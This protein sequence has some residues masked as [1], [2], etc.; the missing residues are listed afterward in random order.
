MIART[1][2]A[3][4]VTEP[5][6]QLAYDLL[7]K[8]L[9]VIQQSSPKLYDEAQHHSFA[10]RAALNEQQLAND[11]RTKRLK[12]SADPIGDLKSEA[13]SAKTKAERDE[14]LLRAAEL[15][16]ERKKFQLCLDILDSID[17]TAAAADSNWRLTIDQLLKNLV[18]ACLTEKIAD[19]A[20]KGLARIGS[21]LTK[22]EGLSM[23][24]RYYTKA[25]EREAAQRLLLEASKVAAS[26]P[27]S[28][29]KAK[30]RIPVIV[31]SDSGRN[32]STDS[33]AS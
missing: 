7:T 20:E 4:F 15:A 28:P 17:I 25:N 19:L 12:E 9:P 16:L 14:L 3:N 29:N 11:A 24:M 30:V 10:I 5:A 22:I 6:P 31:S 23:I 13:E 32:V 2:P 1:Q 33:G 8:L 18:R 21:I 26:G 27:E